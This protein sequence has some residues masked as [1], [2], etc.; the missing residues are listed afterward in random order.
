MEV[1]GSA[2]A[3]RGR[4]LVPSRTLAPGASGMRSGAVVRRPPVDDRGHMSRRRCDWER[5]HG[6]GEGV[7]EKEAYDEGGCIL[8]LYAYQ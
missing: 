5:R 4:R 3:E 2:C 7:R 8:M 6:V 1:A